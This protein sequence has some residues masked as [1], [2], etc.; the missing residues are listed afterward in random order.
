MPGAK[1]IWGSADGG[2]LNGGA[3]RA[4][5]QTLGADPRVVSAGSAAQRLDQVGRA[6]HL[7]WNPL[8]GEIVQLIPILRAGRLLGLPE[9]LGQMTPRP[10][11]AADDELAEANAEGRLCVQIG[12]VAFAW[13]PFTSWPMTGL[14]RILDWLDA[15]DVSR[16]W[17]AGAPAPFPH[18]LTTCGNTRLWA[19]GGHFGASQV[20]GLTTAGPGAIGIEQLT[21]RA[22]QAREP[23]RRAPVPTRSAPEPTASKPVADGPAARAGMRGLDGYFDD[24][25]AGAGA[26]SRVG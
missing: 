24:E 2:P 1:R 4:V 5:W 18:G 6:C 17:P 3:P 22:G 10:P 26:L 8:H 16:R 20:P 14:Q 12:V 7:V 13:D 25:A 19:S 23:D 9:D 21:G 15:W 11:G